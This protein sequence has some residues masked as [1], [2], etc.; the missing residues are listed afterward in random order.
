MDTHEHKLLSLRDLNMRLIKN[1]KDPKKYMQVAYHGQLKKDLIGSQSMNFI[2]VGT[3]CH[4][5]IIED[6][7]DYYADIIAFVPNRG[8]IINSVTFNEGKETFDT[9]SINKKFSRNALIEKFNEVL[10]YN[11]KRE[12][13]THY[14]YG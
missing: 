13:G 14:N 1:T 11:Y 3:W 8:A 5:Y 12:S 4:F 2:K 6:K 10:E 7:N 9:I